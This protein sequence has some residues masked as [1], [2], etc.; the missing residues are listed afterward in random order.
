MN[1]AIPAAEPTAA[2]SREF[3]GLGHLGEPE[4]ATVEVSRLILASA[5]HCELDMVQRV[6]GPSAIIGA[7]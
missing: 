1:L 7:R 2:T 3:A 4:N 6:D 5:R